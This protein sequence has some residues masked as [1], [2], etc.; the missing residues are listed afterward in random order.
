MKREE[1]QK[2]QNI[3]HSLPRL[4]YID[5]DEHFAT[6]TRDSLYLRTHRNGSILITFDTNGINTPNQRAP[7]NSHVY[8]FNCLENITISRYCHRLFIKLTPH[9]QTDNNWFASNWFSESRQP[10]RRNESQTKNTTKKTVNGLFIFF[11]NTFRVAVGF[12][13][14]F[15]FLPLSLPI[16]F[17]FS[18]SLSLPLTTSHAPSVSVIVLFQPLE[19]PQTLNLIKC[20]WFD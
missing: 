16:L 6:I 17:F 8:I 13:L 3:C 18:L 10:Q 9:W 14:F 1:K 15:V 12:Y 7:S 5:I 11:H 19:T 4:F 2:K 20:K